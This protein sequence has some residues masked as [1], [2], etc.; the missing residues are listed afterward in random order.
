MSQA[1]YL[2]KYLAGGSNNSGNGDYMSVD[3][4]RKKKKKKVKTIQPSG[5]RVLDQDEQSKVHQIEKDED[6][7]DEQLDLVLKARS[8]RMKK[9][10]DMK[11]GNDTQNDN[12]SPPRRTHIKSEDISPPRKNTTHTSPPRKTSHIK[13]EDSSPPRRRNNE[14]NSPP[15]KRA[16]DNSPPRKRTTD[17]SPPRKRSADSSPPRK[18]SDDNSPP[19]KRNNN[20]DNSPPRRRNV[21][22]SPPRRRSDDNSPPRKRTT[23]SS[24]P[25][26]RTVDDNSPPRKRN[27][28]N[29]PPRRRNNEDSSPPRKRAA[30]S[31]PPRRDD[32][33][34]KKMSDGYRAGLQSG[35]DVRE[36]A[37]LKLRSQREAFDKADPKLLGR[38]VETV[39]RDKRG[40]KLEGL[41]EFKRQ[42]DGKF[43]NEEEQGLEWGTGLAQKK[44]KEDQKTREEEEKL[45]PFARYR[46][47]ADLDSSLKEQDRWGDPMAGLITKPVSKPK[48][49]GPP[50]APNR[51]GILPG[52]RWDGQDRSNGFEANL[53]KAQARKSAI[54][55]EA[56]L[57]SVS[58]M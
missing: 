33:P 30:D 58:D 50:P 43:V 17:S 15:R 29:S 54:K 8:E 48:Y 53:F 10:L 56:Y 4:I 5:L 3:D 51:F 31:T 35:K 12:D 26:R 1:D 7:N 47:D 14:D 36:Q 55:E 39:Y 41:M 25:R 28:D 11:I 21:D 44:M 32:D 18:R 45:K 19:R 46:D 16:A 9:R 57:W 40:R 42:Q 24:P 22:N 34:K 20:E 6:S 49:R 37:E 2:K 23:D 52:H 13:S 27:H 38:E